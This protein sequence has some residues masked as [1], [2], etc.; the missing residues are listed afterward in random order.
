MTNYP[1]LY[2]LRHGETEWNVEGRL[3]GRHDSPLTAQ[4]RAQARAQNAILKRCD[5]TGFTALTSPQ[6][7]AQDT[8]TIALEG[9]LPFAADEG[10]AEIGLGAWA[11]R[12]RAALLANCPRARDSFD[13]YEEAPGGEGFAALYKRC[14]AFLGRLDGPHVL[15]THGITSRMLRLILTGR[16]IDQLRRIQGGQG[17]VFEIIDG[18]QRRLK[19]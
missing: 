9:L 8:A 6:K 11:G 16:D 12:E 18:Q 3:Q 19:L 1:P 7:R 10:L 14:Q 2:I 13:L 17:V 4:G 15:I 5:L